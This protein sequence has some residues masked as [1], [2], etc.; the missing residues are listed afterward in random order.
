[1]C[2]MCRM[3]SMHR[4]YRMFLEILALIFTIS[5]WVLVASTLPTDY[6]RLSTL[7]PTVV[8]TNFQFSNLWKICV[9]DSIGVTDCKDFPSLLALDGQLFFPS[10][11]TLVCWLCLFF[12]F[13]NGSGQ[14]CQMYILFSVCFLENEHVLTPEMLNGT[15]HAKADNTVQQ[16]AC[17]QLG[18][19]MTNCISCFIVTRSTAH[20]LCV[21][22]CRCLQVDA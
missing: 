18:L 8:A 20:W 17:K 22:R 3:C 15:F 6:W 5:G 13:F 16:S 1:M 7:D 4:K 12:D 14:P 9:T 21:M 11:S 19:L 2:S 10:Y